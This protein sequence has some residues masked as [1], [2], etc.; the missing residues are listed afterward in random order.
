MGSPEERAGGFLAQ[1][2]RNPALRERDTNVATLSRLQEY[3][4]RSG[5][6]QCWVIRRS[7]NE[8]LDKHEAED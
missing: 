4:K 7:L 6:S 2:L 5:R 3:S 8:W 1:A